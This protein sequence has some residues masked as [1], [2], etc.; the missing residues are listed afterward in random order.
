M[1][2]QTVNQEAWALT[3]QDGEQAL[4]DEAE[5]ARAHLVHQH[6]VL[7]ELERAERAAEKATSDELQADTQALLADVTRRFDARESRA[8]DLETIRLLEET[9]KAKDEEYEGL[10]SQAKVIRNEAMNREE[11]YNKNFKN[12]GASA[13]NVAAQ[14]GGMME[15]RD[16]D[17]PGPQHCTKRMCCADMTDR[18]AISARAA[19]GLHGQEGSQESEGRPAG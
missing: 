6:E 7:L 3:T 17:G 12:G 5:A 4:G 19:L 18:A 1:D 2:V 11:T 10:M 9:I 14:G 15:V 13:M 8:E 16:I